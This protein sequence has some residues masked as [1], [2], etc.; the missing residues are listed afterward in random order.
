MTIR[1]TIDQILKKKLL[2]PYLIIGTTIKLIKAV[3]NVSKVNP[4]L[5]A[6]SH[7]VEEVITE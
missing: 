3:C 2:N 5:T 7:R 6:F 1:K 4:G